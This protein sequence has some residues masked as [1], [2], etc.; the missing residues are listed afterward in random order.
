MRKRSLNWSP[1]RKTVLAASV[2]LVLLCALGWWRS[3]QGSESLS[4]WT[5]AINRGEWDAM[6]TENVPQPYSMSIAQQ[7]RSAPVF[8]LTHDQ[9]VVGFH[10][11]LHTFHPG[12]D[13]P[14][15]N[16]LTWSAPAAF[17]ARPA[18]DDRA[19][20]IEKW[21][22]WRYGAW[23]FQFEPVGS[24][25]DTMVHIRMP[26]WFVMLVCASPWMFEGFAIWRRKRFR[27]RGVCGWCDYDL[28]GLPAGSPCPECGGR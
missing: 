1:V 12:E 27:G 3:W 15:T 23:T 5:N 13:E 20:S 19:M 28:R 22:R 26:Y 17:Y 6:A 7:L 14:I 4:L 21:Q 11:G 8:N 16:G 25:P 10:R 9:G 18:P 2:L 24:P